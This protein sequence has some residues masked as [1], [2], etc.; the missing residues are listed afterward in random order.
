M[1]FNK[2]VLTTISTNDGILKDTSSNFGLL[3]ISAPGIAYLE[4]RYSIMQSDLSN[5]HQLTIGCIDSNNILQIGINNLYNYTF[6]SITNN[7]YRHIT[8]QPLGGYVGINTSTPLDI[9]DISSTNAFLIPK[10]STNY[11]PGNVG[12]LTNNIAM[13]RYNTDIH[14]L[15]G[16]ILYN[17]ILEWNTLGGISDRDKDTYIST[18]PN[19]PA[20]GFYVKNEEK[21]T[22]DASGLGINTVN[23]K[24]FLSLY[25]SKINFKDNI[26]SNYGISY[27]NTNNNINI[28]V[29]EFSNNGNICI[30]MP[31]YTGSCIQ[32]TK[33]GSNLYESIISIHK[34][35]KIGINTL[36]PATQLHIYSS[37]NT[38]M[39]IIDNN[40]SSA[41]SRI[42]LKRNTNLYYM[43]FIDG[44]I[45]FN[46]NTSSNHIKVDVY[47]N[48][49][50]NTENP[51]YNLDINGKIN[52]SDTF[53][54]TGILMERG[55]NNVNYGYNSA[56]ISTS[57]S[58]P[59]F[60]IRAADND[61]AG[62]WGVLRL[63]ASDYRGTFIDIDV[64]TS[65]TSQIAMFTS[66]I[67]RLVID[68]NGKVKIKKPVWNSD[69]MS[70]TKLDIGNSIFKT[71]TLLTKKI[72]LNSYGALVYPTIIGNGNNSAITA[73][74][75]R[76]Y[77]H[78]SAPAD[79]PSRY[80][81]SV[82]EERAWG[83]SPN[84]SE[85]LIYN[86][87]TIRIKSGYIRFD[88]PNGS[89][90]T[91][92]PYA[93][94]NGYPSN[95]ITKL[96]IRPTGIGFS[97]DPQYML[98]TGSSA[99]VRIGGTVLKPCEYRFGSIQIGGEPKGG[100]FGFGISTY[101]QRAACLL[102]NGATE[103]GIRWGGDNDNWAIRVSGSDTYLYYNGSIKYTT[104]TGLAPYP[105]RCSKIEG[106]LSM[107][108]YLKIVEE[109][110]STE[111]SSRSSSDYG[112]GV[113]STDYPLH[114]TW[115]TTGEP[116]DLTLKMYA[117]SN[118]VVTFSGNRYP[119]EATSA[120]IKGSIV[121]DG[122]GEAHVHSDERTKTDIILIDDDYCL[123]LLRN[124][125]TKSYKVKNIYGYT[126]TQH[127]FIAQEVEEIYPYCVSRS[128]DA[129]SNVCK[130]LDDIIWI[131]IPII[132]NSLNITYQYKLKSSLWDFEVGKTY[133]FT[134]PE[135]KKNLGSIQIQCNEDGTF[136]FK[137]KYDIVYC[138]GEVVDDFR[139]LAKNKLF[140]INFSATQRLIEKYWTDG[141]KIQTMKNVINDQTT[142]I[143]TLQNKIKNMLPR[144]LSLES[145]YLKHV[146][147]V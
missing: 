88:A 13:V 71:N 61:D 12:Q 108:D 26:Y 116:D 75:R 16:T 141:E 110:S 103:M 30:N 90:N 63:S 10:G 8:I 38:P 24:T 18:K 53:Y 129:I 65:T 94:S 46:S 95:S 31:Q 17:N 6:N 37:N 68:V 15:E 51:E 9:L 33:S 3:E 2:G 41:T 114:V 55:I 57:S 115:T 21:M 23:P 39:L 101:Y 109:G 123:E 78:W 126:K 25:D 130:L 74:W 44:N 128:V 32:F 137:K 70:Q 76:T 87:D 85:L 54:P 118:N 11:R 69:Y 138:V 119:S 147:S 43:D 48:V 22:I 59:G 7:S 91:S 62:G 100:Y 92:D 102:G 86:Q 99:P 122:D 142:R 60:E 145:E 111:T 29:F 47:R 58:V 107:V 66:D 36:N 82:I 117:G 19:G 132:D 83:S 73:Y 20:L 96:L 112:G 125:Q 34:S 14:A 113:S 136:T 52:I 121:I 104:E 97:M 28:P 93:D 144:V 143:E 127:G 35:N 84:L 81:S 5:I 80:R 105:H 67:Q 146:F 1:S 134:L 56:N 27:Y 77:P 42:T 139:S 135:D 72:V 64:G 40:N 79:H 98:D 131:K 45:S 4:N 120:Y 140:H 50:I 49:G 106:R 89:M 133:E 124:I